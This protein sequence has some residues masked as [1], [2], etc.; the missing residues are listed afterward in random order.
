M[1][2]Q[3]QLQLV[4]SSKIIDIRKRNLLADNNVCVDVTFEKIEL[5]SIYRNNCFEEV[6]E[7]FIFERYK[8]E[9]DMRL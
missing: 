2:E 5:Q 7:N 4:F 3:N 8:Q 6:N 1:R 9:T